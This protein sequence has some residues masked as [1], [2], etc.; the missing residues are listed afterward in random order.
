MLKQIIAVTG[1]NL[2]SLPQ[3]WSSSLVTVIGIASVVAVMISL[4]AISAGMIQ[5]ADRGAG[6]NRVIVL[7]KGSTAAYMGSISREQVAII[8]DAPGV[9]QGPD[10]KPMVDPQA[11]VIVEVAK[12]EGGTTNSGFVGSSERWLK[13]DPDFKLIRGRMFRPAVREMIV[14]KNAAKQF[15]N[16]DVGDHITLRGS[17]WEVVGVF[18]R[19][20]SLSEN[21]MI[22]DPDTVLAAFERNTFQNVTAELQSP[23]ALKR[24]KD[25][26][27]SNPQ[28]Q[29]DVK[30]ESQ[31]ARDQLSQLTVLL[32]FVA[33]FVGSVMAVGAVFGAINTMY[34]AVDSRAREIATLRAIGFGG[35]AVVVSVLVEALALALPGAL[36]GALVAWL[37]FNGNSAQI[38]SLSFP[39]AVTPPLVLLGIIWSLVIG[40]IGGFMPSIRAARLQVATVLRAV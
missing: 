15:K 22:A 23:E 32:N 5:S 35:T 31:Y 24:F 30:L 10:G 12:K 18:E 40:L 37:L 27:T 33:Y 3:R 6:K 1:M 39:L 16:M 34:S 19:N 36:L 29:V 21:A 17:E 14:G 7:N 8:A 11:T 20:G 9:R 38:A 4:L 25:S 28:L 13:L 2:R 26:V